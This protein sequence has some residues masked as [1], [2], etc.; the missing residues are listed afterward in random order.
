MN[1]DLITDPV[2]PEIS[3]S[4]FEVVQ[5][6][7]KKTQKPNLSVTLDDQERISKPEPPILNKSINH[8]LREQKKSLTHQKELLA[9]KLRQKLKKL[10]KQQDLGNKS[11]RDMSQQI[12]N[13]FDKVRDKL[14]RIQDQ[15][16]ESMQQN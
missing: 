6:S 13:L 4:N 11:F 16:I 9:V 3:Q 5:P 1:E 10:C 14:D 15:E 7:P 2:V 8:E 12:G